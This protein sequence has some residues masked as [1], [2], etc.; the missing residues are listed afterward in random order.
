MNV[1]IEKLD[2]AVQDLI[3]TL[4]EG[5][6][7]TAIWDRGTGLSLAEYN[8][9]PAAVALF[10]TLTNDLAGTL[11]GANYP[12]I[13]Q[14]YFLELTAGNTVLVIQ[15]GPDILQGLLMDA[16]KV[17]LGVLLAVVVPQMIAAVQKARLTT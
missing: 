6:I 7:A 9:Q 12:G 10:T 15:H 8:P 5:L 13:N 14:Y 1:N 3:K 11:A 16:Q 4:K 2:T 17:N